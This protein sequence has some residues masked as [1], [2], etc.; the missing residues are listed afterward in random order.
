MALDT[1]PLPQTTHQEWIDPTFRPGDFKQDLITIPL[2]VALIG[3]LSYF[4]T[5][6][7]KTLLPF[8][9]QNTNRSND[10]TTYTRSEMLPY[11]IGTGALIF[12]GLSLTNNH[13]HL[14]SQARGFAHA[15]LLSEVAATSAKVIFQV[16]RPNYNAQFQPNNGI[17]TADSRASFYS[18]HANQAFTFSTYT[19][20]LMFHYSN[21]I[22]VSSLYS[23]FAFSV[24]SIVSYSR[25]TDNAHNLSDVIVGSIMGATISAL[26][27]FRVQM[28]VNETDARSSFPAS[29]FNWSVSPGMIRNDYGKTWIT[30]D[31][32]V[33]I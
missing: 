18:N 22:V 13:F 4:Y 16:K 6:R 25:V 7:S 8:M 9:D 21:S 19:S 17:E 11:T 29:T 30:A 23:A 32:H 26:T 12:A 15:I 14:W 20:L 31:I 33:D 27:F 28:I 10:E 5:P 3:A 2:E 24:S 1:V